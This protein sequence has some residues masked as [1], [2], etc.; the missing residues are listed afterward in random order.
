MYYRQRGNLREIAREIGRCVSTVSRELTRNSARKGG[1][2]AVEAEKKY[3][4]RRKKCK[5]HNLLSNVELQQLVRRLFLEEQWSPEQIAN[6]LAHENSVCRIS[7]ST[8]YRAIYAGIFNT[9]RQRRFKGNRGAVR[10]LRHRGKT[11]RRKGTV[12][13]RGKIV[14]S[15][16]IQERPQEA[17]DRRSIG[18]W[19]ADTLAG[20]TGSA[21][22]VTIPD[23]CSRYLLAG[24]VAKKGSVL[25][26]GEMIKLLSALPKEKC[27]TITPDRGK[28]F[29]N[30][31]SVT[32]ALNGLPFYFPDLHAA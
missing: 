14:I 1:D 26:C 8:I 31:G 19:E 5:S 10:K 30:H 32:Q 12:E 13:T 29:S 18:H 25:V 24:R 17:N 4:D 11:S 20:K 23:R 15:N 22:L 27:R 9:A 16:R 6:R 28:E 21:C 7:Y 2:S 3:R